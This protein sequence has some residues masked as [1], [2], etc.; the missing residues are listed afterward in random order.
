MNTAAPSIDLATY[1]RDTAKR[2][3][4]ASAALA[5]LDAEIKNRWLN[6]SADALTASVDQIIAANEQDL[7]AAPG[8]GLTDAAVDRLRLNADRIGGI[9]TALREVSMLADPVGEVL[10]G[11]TRPGGL[12]I[13]KKRVPL[14]V[15]F[16]IYESRPNVTADAAA[17]CV[18]SGNAVILRG[19]KEAIHSSRAIVDLLSAAA[20]NCGL[21]P[22]A[23]Q[24]VSTTDRSAVGEFLSLDQYI[25]VAIPRG[26]EGLIRRVTSEATMPVIKH[27]DGNCHVYVDQSA[28]VDMAAKIVHNAKC[29]RMGVCNA[30]ESLLVHESIAPSALPV[31][32]ERLQAENVEIRADQAAAPLIPGSV[33]A[34]EEDWGTEYLGPVI[35]VA[36]VRSID[37]AIKH[38]NRYGSHH[39]DAIITRD[40]AAA[41]TFTA[42]VDSSAVMVNASTRFNDGGVFGLGAEIG[43]ST[44]KF[45]ARGPCGLRELTTYKYIVKGDGQIRT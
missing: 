43:I 32:A 36:V 6:E 40:L 12:Q 4:E 39:T 33:P 34:S 26:G 44:D 24:L 45:H 9:A 13:L 35:S 3:K 7:A 10:D 37:D 14:G 8:Y 20:E 31:I 15:V 27:Y 5:T 19:G 25:D 18:K 22:A 23:V 42:G 29:Q 1:C 38:I 41:E 16:F 2:A 28:D 30:C 17:I 11:F 21:P